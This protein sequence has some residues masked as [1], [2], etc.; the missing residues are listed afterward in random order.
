VLICFYQPNKLKKLNLLVNTSIMEYYYTDGLTNFGPFSLEQLKEKKITPSTK[1]WYAGLS[2]WTAAS[3]IPELAGLLSSFPPPLST[4]P[5]QYTHQPAMNFGQMKP[6]R[7]WLVESILVTLFCCL[8]FGIAGI[9]YA[10]RVESKFYA[11]DF[12]GAQQA[13]NDAGKWTRIGFWIGIAILILYIIYIIGIVL[14]ATKNGTNLED[15][16]PTF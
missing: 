11:G 1:I 12:A 6:P 15:L 9:I 7:T 5:P 16:S 10:A 14:L 3:E 2:G 4:P 13:S 8:P